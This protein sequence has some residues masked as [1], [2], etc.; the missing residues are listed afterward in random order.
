MSHYLLKLL[1]L[2]CL[3]SLTYSKRVVRVKWLTRESIP[4]ETNNVELQLKTTCNENFKCCVWGKLGDAQEIDEAG[5]NY[6]SKYSYKIKNNQC[7]LAI[8]R[9]D[10]EKDL[11][12][13]KVEP[14]LPGE[15]NVFYGL[16]YFKSIEI[17]KEKINRNTYNYTCVA[18]IDVADS[19]D[20]KLNDELK[21]SLHSNI[22][23]ETGESENHAKN[24]KLKHDSS[25]LNLKE[26]TKNKKNEKRQE[27]YVNS[28]KI[29]LDPVTIYSTSASNRHFYCKINLN[30]QAS[31]QI[32]YENVIDVKIGS[33]NT[34]SALKA[35]G[36]N[37]FFLVL[38]LSLSSILLVF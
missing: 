22:Y 7:N 10:G 3:L 20:N 4:S 17:K 14:N 21:K 26:K 1:V 18:E 16:A 11:D 5:Q 23:L 19:S 15:A 12:F 38:L 34:N 36:V 35:I 37:N 6:G 28:I 24:I 31:K 32:V 8:T 33:E 29:S 30:D 9:Y 2:V 13:Y 27:H 25:N